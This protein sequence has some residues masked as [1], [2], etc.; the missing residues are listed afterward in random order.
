MMKTVGPLSGKNILITGGARRIGRAIA[1]SLAQA[2]ATILIHHGFSPDEARQTQ[3][4]IQASGAD[5]YILQA[6][7]AK[8]R[9]VTRLYEKANMIGPIYGLINNAALFKN[10]TLEE[11]SLEDWQEAFNINLTAPFLLSQAFARSLS[12]GG[13]GRIVN[14]LDWRALRPVTDH[15]PYSISKAA[16]AAMTRS[17]AAA[18]APGII[19]NGLALGAILPPEDGRN[20]NQTDLISSVP[21]GRWGTLDEVTQTVLYLLTSSDYM[22][23]EVLHLDGGRHLV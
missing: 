17:M 2:G 22:T 13:H 3:A 6:D 21:A 10:I 16:L 23:G 19:V 11:T 15:F 20:T 1:L 18:L 14:L 7:L 5:A 9:Q 8:P 12:G 4:D